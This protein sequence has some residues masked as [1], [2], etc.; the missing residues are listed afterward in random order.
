M[1]CEN[2][3]NYELPDAY[4]GMT[5][6]GL[7]WEISDVTDN[8]TEFA[9]TLT[10]ARFQIQDST[11]AAALTLSSANSGE[12]TINTATA[13]AWSITVESRVLSLAT[14]TYS[15]CLVTTDSTGD[16]KPRMQGSIRVHTAPII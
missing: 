11:G 12:V 3:I 16:V 14:G 4:K 13:N 1:S 15:Y 9:G 5:W 7:T 6:D 2:V 10:L 8:D